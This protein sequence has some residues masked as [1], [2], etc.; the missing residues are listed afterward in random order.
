QSFFDLDQGG[1]PE[2]FT[3]RRIQSTAGVKGS[4]EEVLTQIDEIQGDNPKSQVFFAQSGIGDDLYI[5]YIA[6]KYP[7]FYCLS[8][9]TWIDKEEDGVNGNEAVY[10][11]SGLKTEMFI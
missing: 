10:D 8:N 6:E 9:V 1:K 4:R 11:R 7:L 3:L 2:F 5:V